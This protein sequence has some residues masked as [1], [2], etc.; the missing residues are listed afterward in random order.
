M[1]ESA[2]ADDRPAFAAS[3]RQAL[4]YGWFTGMPALAVLVVLAGPI[5]WALS[6][7][8]LREGAA[9][10]SLAACIG[11]L[12]VAQL[13]NG[14]HEVGRQALFARLD[15]RGPQLAGAVA[16]VVTAL[17]GGA[18]LLLPA[19]TPRLVGLCV[20]L[21]LADLASAATV[22]GLVHR[23][24]RPERGFDRYRLAAAA[25][26]AL[27]MVP[28]LALGLLLVD[29]RSSWA[30]QIAVAAGAALLATAVFVLGL[31]RLIASRGRAA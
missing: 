4:S 26:A 20:A 5:A 30:L 28:V 14:A 10:T 23:A 19:G 2:Q 18:A 12:G 27:A 17:A 16:F 25:A 9:M 13:A 6:A 29:Q 24:I 15:S 31:R 8:E 1:S 11:V 22:V 7:G 21:L 3:W